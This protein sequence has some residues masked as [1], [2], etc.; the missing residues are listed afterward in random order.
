[1]N[2]V[3]NAFWPAVLLLLVCFASAQAAELTTQDYVEIQQLYARYN[4][5]I[6]SGDAEGWAG[7]FTPDGVFNQRFT[8]R[9]GLLEF[10]KQWKEKM[11]GANRRHW[12]SNLLITPSAEGASGKVLLMLLDVSTRPPSIIMTGQYTDVLVKTANG[13]RFKSRDVKN[14]AA[15]AKT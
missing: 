9:E 13:W 5:A 11:N 3:S 10:M 4:H 2:K 7:T 6:D 12:N 1:M 8:G 14:D 15:P